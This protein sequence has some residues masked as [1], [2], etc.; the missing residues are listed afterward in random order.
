MDVLVV[1]FYRE[2]F[3]DLERETHAESDRAGIK[4]CQSAI[5]ITTSAAE[6]AAARSKGE[7]WDEHTIQC[8]VSDPFAVHGLFEFA[9]WL[10]G[11]MEVLWRSDGAPTE[12]WAVDAGKDEAFGGMLQ[13]G[14]KIG[15]P[16]KRGEESHG[17]GPGPHG[18]ALDEEE[19][20][21]G[22]FL[23]EC[24]GGLEAGAHEAAKR[25]FR[26]GKLCGNKHKR[27]TMI[28]FARSGFIA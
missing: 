6:A 16:R 24:C 5:V 18:M 27:G 17:G 19:E 3:D 23:D 22:A 1:G 21:A 7:P 10:G 2:A 15:L 25:C 28:H 13:Q 26:G 12:F 14:Q 8:G 4:G 11:R 9:V 20:R